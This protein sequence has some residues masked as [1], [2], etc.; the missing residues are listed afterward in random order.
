MRYICIRTVLDFGSLGEPSCVLHFGQS[1][2]QLRTLQSPSALEFNWVGVSEFGVKCSV[3]LVK[4]FLYFSI[5]FVKPVLMFSGAV[6]KRIC[7]SIHDSLAQCV[8]LFCS[9]RAALKRQRWTIWDLCKILQ[10]GCTSA[11]R[12]CPSPQAAD[13][14]P[15]LRFL[16]SC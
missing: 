10:Y 15:T 5:I 9:V 13:F 11:G 12:I 14:K 6:T 3:P 16:F 2:L 4:Q 7:S 1:F 8:P